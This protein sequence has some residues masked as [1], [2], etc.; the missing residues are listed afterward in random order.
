MA[1]I[2][3]AIASRKADG[4]QQWQDGYPNRQTIEADIHH[5]FAY[6]LQDREGQIAAYAAVIDEPEPAYEQLNTWLNSQTY[7]TIHRVAI[8]PEFKGQGI[9]THIFHQIHELA[10]Q[11]GFQNIKVDTNF[12]NLPMLHILQ[13]LQYTYCGEVYFRGSPRRAY[14]KVLNNINSASSC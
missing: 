6:I 7:I 2:D 8:A 4:S 5:K 1:I 14:Q 9:A 13:K 12:D 10:I 3:F 11:K